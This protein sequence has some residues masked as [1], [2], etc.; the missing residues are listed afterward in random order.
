MDI[1]GESATGKCRTWNEQ[2]DTRNGI[3]IVRYK[4]VGVCWNVEINILYYASNTKKHVAKSPYRISGNVYSEKCRCPQAIDQ[5]LLNYKCDSFYEQINSDLKP[6]SRVN[7]TDLQPKILRTFDQP[8]SIAI[9]HY[10]VKNNNIFRKCYGQHTGFKMFIDAQLS[11][12]VR[13]VKLPD[14]EFFVNLG[15][16]PLVKKGGLSRTHGPYPMFSWC[17]SD[18]TFDIV[19]PTYDITESSLEA[20]S[21]VSID[22]L[23][24]QN[25][26]RT[27]EEKEPIAFWRGRD[28][29]RERLTLV[30][31]SRKYPNLFNVSLT[32]FFFF[33]DEEVKYGPKQPHISFFEFFDVRIQIC[34]PNQ[35][36]KIILNV[37]FLV[38]IPN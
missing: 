10:V 11:A 34:I 28:S 4:T 22:I 24:V 31:I 12:L 38:Q 32:N 26:K 9:C 13:L 17:G 29:R 16:W 5:W 8:A 25:A 33:R 1:F 18:N 19:M 7:F 23:S 2:L 3:Y 6:F 35:T 14:T 37:F 36:S 27:W 15:D 21:R 20:M 30:D